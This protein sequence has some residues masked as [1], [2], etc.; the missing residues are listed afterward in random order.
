M[1]LAT[2]AGQYPENPA[3]QAL[4]FS[5]PFYFRDIR[6]WQE[7][8]RS[9]IAVTKGQ[10]KKVSF[11]SVLIPFLFQP[12]PPT[13]QPAPNIPDQQD[14]NAELGSPHPHGEQAAMMQAAQEALLPN[15]KLRHNFWIKYKTLQN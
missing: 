6:L 12:P 11:L 7:T 13:R 14:H 1:A 3:Q 4:G 8:A 9:V 10:R 15:Q 5:D 2:A